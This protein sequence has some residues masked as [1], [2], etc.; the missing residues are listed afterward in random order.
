[1]H[2]TA[3]EPEG[4][5]ATDGSAET[6]EALE[7]PRISVLTILVGIAVPAVVV[8]LA[9]EG[10]PF[11]MAPFQMV[12][13]R[14]R[15][16]P[17]LAAGAAVVAW[18]VG[19][20]VAT[21]LNASGYILV[22][23][24]A[25]TSILGPRFWWL[26]AILVLAA[27]ARAFGADEGSYRP[28]PALLLMWVLLVAGAGPLAIQTLHGPAPAVV[29][30]AV[31]YRERAEAQTTVARSLADEGRLDEALDTFSS[32]VISASNSGELDLLEQ[33]LEEQIELANR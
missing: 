10:L 2:A 20:V 13:S 31:E 29:P 16:E 9:L 24:L 1:V 11:D 18:I 5:G 26:F 12:A 6:P 32:A 8:T 33:L 28:H 3:P 21:Q 17:G 15:I 25:A 30:T 19:L 27:G 14:F 22:S 7:P 4:E 23:A